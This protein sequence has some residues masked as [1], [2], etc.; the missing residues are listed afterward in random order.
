MES[1]TITVR[2]ESYRVVVGIDLG[3]EL[4][5]EIAKIH[6]AKIAIIT[7]SDVGKL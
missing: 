5:K 6:P 2:G 7:D 4:L 1:I 3:A